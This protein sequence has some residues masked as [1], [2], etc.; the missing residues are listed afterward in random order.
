MLTRR[1]AGIARAAAAASKAARDGSVAHGVQTL[2]CRR[3]QLCPRPWQK[4]YSQRHAG[5]MPPA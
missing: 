4:Q 3:P 5:I 1:N 2:G